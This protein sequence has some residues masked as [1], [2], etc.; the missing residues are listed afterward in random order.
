MQEHIDKGNAVRFASFSPTDGLMLFRTSQAHDREVRAWVG[1]SDSGVSIVDSRRVTGDINKI[2][3]LMRNDGVFRRAVIAL[4]DA[5]EQLRWLLGLPD[6]H[7]WHT[8]MLAIVCERDDQR[9]ESDNMVSLHVS[10][11]FE[12]YSRIEEHLNDVHSYISA[13]SKEFIEDFPPR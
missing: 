5:L 3:D 11:T 2:V 4:P 13:W 7:M 1:S 8:C 6:R 12:Q 10:D 9:Q